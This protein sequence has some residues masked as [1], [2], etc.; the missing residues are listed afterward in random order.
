MKGSATFPKKLRCDERAPADGIGRAYRQDHAHRRNLRHRALPR[1][2]RQSAD[3]PKSL[4]PRDPENTLNYQQ[5][6]E[7]CGTATNAFLN[8]SRSAGL[9]T[10]RLLLLT[11]EPTAKHVVAEVHLRWSLG[12]LST[13]S[14]AYL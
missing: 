2:P 13:L 6:L 4:S 12:D 5:L 10:R 1:T 11:T 3:H 14:I 7:V 8:L 9:E